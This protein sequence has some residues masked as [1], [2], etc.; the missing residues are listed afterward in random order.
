MD[1]IK[2]LY[3]RLFPIWLAIF[4][5]ILYF[6]ILSVVSL[7]G[8]QIVIIEALSDYLFDMSILYFTIYGFVIASISIL[9]TVSSQNKNVWVALIEKG[10]IVRVRLST[11]IILLFAVLSLINSVFDIQSSF[12]VICGVI[13]MSQTYYITHY[14]FAV[15]KRVS[16]PVLI[17]EN[18][19]G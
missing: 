9:V 1:T 13:V 3:N 6:I 12:S 5:V 11:H 10:Y 16:K 8:F 14:V 17:N 4:C 2:N 15:S 7:F 19:K 18:T